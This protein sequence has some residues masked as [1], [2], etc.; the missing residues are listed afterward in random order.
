LSAIIFYSL[1]LRNFL[2]YGNNTSKIN[3]NFNKPSLIIGKNYDSVVDG[4]VE[5]NG[6][7][8]S[9]IINAL[10][11]C[12][13]DETLMN[14]N[15]KNDLINIYNEKNLVVSLNFS[16]GAVY[17]R[18]SRF[19]KC[20]AL[21]GNGVSI[22]KYND[23]SFQEY[24]D[25][26]PD[27]INNAN[28]FIED[29][30]GI[31][32]HSFSRIVVFS[33]SY[34]PFLS[35]PQSSTTGPNQRDILEEVFGLTILSKK[36][37]ILKENIKNKKIE[38]DKNVAVFAEILKQKTLNDNEIKEYSLKE[39][40]WNLK[41]ATSIQKLKEEEA[42]A[43][44]IDFSSQK[45]IFST[46]QKCDH[47]KNELAANIKSKK[48]EIDN[49][50]NILKMKND[51]DVAKEAKIKELHNA[52]KKFENIDFE[53]I[54]NR[55]EQ[56]NNFTKSYKEIESEAK[57]TLLAFKKINADYS[58][59]S[60]DLTSLQSSKCPYCKQHYSSQEAIN[61]V[62]AEIRS[63]QEELSILTTT[64]NELDQNIEKINKTILSLKEKTNNYLSISD[65]NKDKELFNKIK[66]D[67]TYK[68]NEINPYLDMFNNLNSESIKIFNEELSELNSKNNENIQEIKDLKEKLLFSSL[69]EL[70]SVE[71][72]IKIIKE[73]IKSLEEA[74]NPY[75]E[76]IS[77]LK[78]KK[79]NMELSQ[80]N[81][82]DSVEL[83]HMTF[84]YA[85]LTKKDSFI[86]KALIKSR[87]ALL[88]EKMMEYITELSLPHQIQFKEDMGIDIK[89]FGKEISINN[90]SSG[91]QARINLA[92]SFAFRHILQLNTK[93]IN[94]CLLDE[95]LDIGLSSVGVQLATKMIKKIAIKNGISMFLITHKDEV[96]TV[97]DSKLEIE[98]RN[99]F[100]SVVQSDTGNEEIIEA[101]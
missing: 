80:T 75:V 39:K 91:Q 90:L 74:V 48:A 34:Q 89:N 36:A 87:L 71:S 54:E 40:E 6:A 73:K 26:T 65:L 79:F 15:S 13:Y 25:I 101:E 83:N 10:C 76:I 7:G 84:L 2:S 43:S 94:F 42:T 37:D 41:T 28:K 77:A 31:T 55:L 63:K 21:G 68:E 88:N 85:L 24:E 4:N 58:K 35:L 97:F 86:R 67:L 61:K 18:I 95:T 1:E 46:L 52:I 100:S 82:D 47:L 23:S 66:N 32:F 93:K 96:S 81:A 98:L 62:E 29:L 3:L 45:N 27:S 16:I 12:L 11:Y 53:K 38:L 92:L 8:K 69:D 20:K 14:V 64:K 51:W 33:A 99:G 30:L 59:L 78:N 57:N 19:R 50:N 17:Y 22:L 44:N 49:F 5:S 9:S 60:E 72:S 56:I 70:H